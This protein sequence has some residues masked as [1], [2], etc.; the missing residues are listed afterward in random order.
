M[1]PC[2]RVAGLAVNHK[3][4]FMFKRNRSSS[5]LIE[6]L[7]Q[8]STKSVHGLNHGLNP[9]FNR[10]NFSI[11]FSLVLDAKAVVGTELL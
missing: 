8:L 5:F 11:L 10:E 7:K 6:S 4:D 1:V 9:Q 2:V 3:K